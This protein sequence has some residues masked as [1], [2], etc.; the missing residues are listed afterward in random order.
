VVH[1]R[2]DYEAMPHLH[3][4]TP[5]LIK[6]VLIAL[7]HMCINEHERNTVVGDDAEIQTN[8]GEGIKG[9]VLDCLSH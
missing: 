2:E 9:Q 4:R 5:I 6:S 1:A 8:W 3:L 7:M